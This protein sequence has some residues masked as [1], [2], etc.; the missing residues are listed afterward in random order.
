MADLEPDDILDWTPLELEAGSIVW[1]IKLL[2]GYLWGAKF[3]IF[4]DHNAL[5]SIGQV[6]DHKD[7]NAR[8]HRWL[9]CLTA[10]DYTLEYKHVKTSRCQ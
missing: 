9:E 3:R 7:R 10:F 5:E 1:A 2:R 6:G 4:S 8:V